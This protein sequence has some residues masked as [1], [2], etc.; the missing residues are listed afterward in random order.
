MGEPCSKNCG[1][2][3]T[4]RVRTIVRHAEF[5]GK[6]CGALR[7]PVVGFAPCNE[8]KCTHGGTCGV[9]HVRCDVLMLEHHKSNFGIRTNLNTCGHSAIEEQNTCWNNNSCKSCRA[10]NSNVDHCNNEACHDAD[11]DS[12]RALQKRLEDDYMA[13]QAGLDGNDVA[14][15]HRKNQGLPQRQ[16]RK[17]F[18]TLQVTHDRKHM[19]VLTNFKCAKTSATT[20]ACRCDKHPACC[21][22]KNKLLSN[23]MLFGNRFNDIDSLQDCCNLCT[24]HPSC[25]AWEYTTER[26]CVLKSGSP[27]YVAN[28]FPGDVTSWSGTPSGVGTC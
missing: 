26:I 23:D 28:P 16:C 10:T 6:S 12:E 4:H 25:G 9:E 21:A 8:H 3:G 17:L 1:Q 18:P 14:N 20:C 5:G 24:N 13:C 27:E 11:T 15:V 19:D 7:D 22:K 2:G